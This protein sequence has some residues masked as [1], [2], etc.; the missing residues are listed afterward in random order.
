VSVK[1][2]ILFTTD[3]SAQIAKYALLSSNELHVKGTGRHKW[4][5]LLCWKK[6]DT[7]VVYNMY[8]DG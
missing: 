7:T 2:V 4:L 1:S 5:S 6:V 8:E 3:Q